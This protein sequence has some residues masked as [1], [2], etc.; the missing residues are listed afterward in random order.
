M[1]SNCR[2]GSWGGGSNLKIERE[3]VCSA[4]L[5]D[6]KDRTRLPNVQI[7]HS[8]ELYLRYKIL[9]PNNPK[10]ESRTLIVLHPKH[11]P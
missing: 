8:I 3:F 9:R 4:C 5:R 2:N 7:K 11:N 6:K 1:N 10:I